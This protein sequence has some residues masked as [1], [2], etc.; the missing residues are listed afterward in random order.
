MNE[1]CRRTDHKG[2]AFV[3]FYAL[4]CKFKPDFKLNQN[5]SNFMKI[6]K[7]SS[8]KLKE[9]YESGDFELRKWAS[10]TDSIL[11]DLTH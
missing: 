6:A 8:Q 9:L 11:V 4:E 1:T 7:I 5:Y 3:V 2:Y 10:I